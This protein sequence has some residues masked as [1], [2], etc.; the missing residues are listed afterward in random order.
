MLSRLI[1][2][3]LWMLPLALLALLLLWTLPGQLPPRGGMPFPSEVLLDVPP[4]FQADPRWGDER[5]AGL[6]TT[7]AQEGC[8]VAALAMVLASY[9]LP[10]DPLVLNRFLTQHEGFTERGWLRWD[11]V[12]PIAPGRL[13]LAYE[14]VASYFLLDL[15]LCCRNPT[16]IR[17]RYPS[18]LTHFFVVIGKRGTDYLVLDPAEAG[19]NGP[20][21]LQNFGSKIEALRYYLATP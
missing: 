19:R 2:I 13:R 9:Q 12:P 8:A 16:I 17:V 21:P 10:C 1:R 3:V 4:F 20:Y 6:D 15:N 18:G 5:L 11:Q 14:G 7:L